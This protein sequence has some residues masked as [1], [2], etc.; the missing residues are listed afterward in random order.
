MLY[1][2]GWEL[3]HLPTKETLMLCTLTTDFGTID[4]YVAQMKATIIK[5]CPQ[6]KFV[7]LTH[8]ISQGNIMQTQFELEQS[9]YLFPPNTV[10]LVVVDPTVGSSRH[11]IIVK[12][13]DS[14]LVGPDNGIFTSFLE[15]GSS[16]HIIDKGINPFASKTFHGRDIFAPACGELLNGKSLE[17]IAPEILETPI[18][19][20]LPTASIKGSTLTGIVWKIDHFGNV[21]TSIRKSDLEIVD[22]TAI[23]INYK[24]FTDNLVGTFPD[25]PA[26]KELAYT[27]S[28][29]FLELAVNSGNCSELWEINPGDPVEII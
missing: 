15:N 4:T 5:Y 1:F 3:K 29:G 22:I 14:Y 17:E 6:V 9:I 25:V 19:I 21:I 18:K 26:G 2:F 20:P 8:H 11:P 16:C 7:D 24:H 10:H 13:K 12:W 27:G 28:A 23:R